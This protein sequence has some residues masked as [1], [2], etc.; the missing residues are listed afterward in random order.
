M[1]SS[2]PK[3]N[4]VRGNVKTLLG[5][6]EL[7]IHS[8]VDLIFGPKSKIGI[9]LKE[10]TEVRSDDV[11]KMIRTLSLADSLNWAYEEDDNPLP[12]REI[13]RAIEKDNT[14]GEILLISPA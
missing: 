14:A 3:I 2:N 10:S 4:F 8:L 6:Q 7:T 12:K 13:E 1:E 9:F 11:M 5:Q